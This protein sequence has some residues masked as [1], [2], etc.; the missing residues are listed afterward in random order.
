M[1][2]L[3]KTLALQLPLWQETPDPQQE[4]VRKWQRLLRYCRY[5]RSLREYHANLNPEQGM[6]DGSRR[7]IPF[8]EMFPDGDVS[9]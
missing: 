2:R 4:Y 9:L 7:P 3:G 5:G 1:D 6:P 8:D